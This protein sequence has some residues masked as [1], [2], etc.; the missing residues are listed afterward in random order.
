MSHPLYQLDNVKQIYGSRTVLDIPQLT[1]PQG[2]VLALVGPSGAGKST[3]L[4]LLAEA[5]AHPRPFIIDK[6]HFFVH[7]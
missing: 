3:M 2:E 6:E 1:L 7:G 5:I 4:R